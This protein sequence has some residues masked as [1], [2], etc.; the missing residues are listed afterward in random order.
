M[1]VVGGCMKHFASQRDVPP[2][3]PSRIKLVRE[4]LGLSPAR[5]A[6]LLGVSALSVKQWEQGQSTPFVSTWQQIVQLEMNGLRDQTIAAGV[7]R[8]PQVAY[9]AAPPS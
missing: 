2:D 3:F 4:Q 7:L 6:G 8:D 9:D 5:F 1:Y